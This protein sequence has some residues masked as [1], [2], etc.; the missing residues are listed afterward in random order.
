MEEVKKK[1][2]RG[3]ARPGGGRPS[4]GP[5]KPKS[6]RMPVDIANL[7]ENYAETTGKTEIKILCE[8]LKQ[9]IEK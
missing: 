7:L 4:K 1:S 3:G 2:K 5:T 9:Y 6:Y 8:A